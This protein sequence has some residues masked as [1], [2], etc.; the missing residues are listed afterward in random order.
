MNLIG[1]EYP[2]QRLCNCKDWAWR[3]AWLEQRL[4]GS[5]IIKVTENGDQGHVGP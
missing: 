4:K 1:K 2:S 5:E 3:T